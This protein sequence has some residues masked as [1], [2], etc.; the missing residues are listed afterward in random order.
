VGRVFFGADSQDEIHLAS[1]MVDNPWFVHA[2]PIGV[3]DYY[4]LSQAAQCM[5]EMDSTI[6]RSHRQMNSLSL[7]Q[8]H[9]ATLLA[10]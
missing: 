4:E 5:T 1:T 6:R 2:L 10:K 7:D 9:S 3:H 8:K